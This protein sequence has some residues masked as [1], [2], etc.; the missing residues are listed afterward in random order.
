MLVIIVPSLVTENL[1]SSWFYLGWL[2]VSLLHRHDLVCSITVKTVLPETVKGDTVQKPHWL[3]PA[4]GKTPR[5]NFKRQAETS[6]FSLFWV[7]LASNLKFL[8]FIT[9]VYSLCTKE[10]VCF[11]ENLVL[12]SWTFFLN[13]ILWKLANDGYLVVEIFYS[14]RNCSYSKQ[15]EASS[16]LKYSHY[17][18]LGWLNSTHTTAMSEDTP[19]ALEFQSI[20]RDSICIQGIVLLLLLWG[21]FTKIVSVDRGMGA[22]LRLGQCLAS[23]VKVNR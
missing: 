17:S 11:S 19:C 8:L 18:F 13:N 1:I 6:I 12:S 22:R 7:T 9:Q 23:Y 15:A 5:V 10:K 2:L 4:E 3:L 21:C 14:P 20:S 16:L